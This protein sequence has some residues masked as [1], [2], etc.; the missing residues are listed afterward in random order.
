MPDK[1]LR[2]RAKRIE[3]PIWQPR[4]RHLP[5]IRRSMGIPR[6]RG[7][8]LC[9]NWLC[10]YNGTSGLPGRFPDIGF[11]LHVGLWPRGPVPP[12][13]G[14]ELAL[15]GTVARRIGF[16]SHVCPSRC[17]GLPA[18]LA[19]LGLF[20]ANA[21]TRRVGLAPPMLLPRC[22]LGL[23]CAFRLLGPRGGRWDGAS[24]RGSVPI[25]NRRIGFVSHVCPSRYPG[26]AEMGLFGAN[27]PTRRVDPAPRR[28]ESRLG[29]RLTPPIPFPRCKLGL[30]RTDVRHAV[31][32]SP[33]G[34]TFTAQ[35]VIMSFCEAG[36][37]QSQI[38]NHESEGVSLPWGAVA[39][40]VPRFC[41]RAGPQNCAS[42]YVR[43]NKRFLARGPFQLLNCCTN[44]VDSHRFAGDFRN[45]GRYG[46]PHHSCRTLAGMFAAGLRP[47]PL[48]IV[49]A[50]AES[51]YAHPVI[52]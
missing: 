28:D 51:G 45:G 38:V 43:R 1:H 4:P 6:L 7:G 20:G 26:Q 48:G 15:F 50:Y 46:L 21:P 34:L 25:R 36:N 32:A 27:A 17:P 31:P 13:R 8:R 33:G 3:V 35:I 47:R 42:P 37:H 40:I 2:S 19:E 52:S 18:D 24:R 12:G 23:F 11:V 29:S 30:F 39:G 44:V 49:R 10:L 14:R 16:V 5:S 41:A 9:Q 22:K